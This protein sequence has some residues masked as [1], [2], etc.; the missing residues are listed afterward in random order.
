MSKRSGSEAVLRQ[1]IR[2]SKR[3]WIQQSFKRPGSICRCTFVSKLLSSFRSPCGCGRKS[4]HTSLG[5]F[6]TVLGINPPIRKKTSICSTR[7]RN[8]HR[9]LKAR[10]WF[11][12]TARENC[13]ERL[14]QWQA[15]RSIESDRV[16][17]TSLRIVDGGRSAVSRPDGES[18]TILFLTFDRQDFSTGS[19]R[20]FYK[21]SRLR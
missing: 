2:L 20:Q 10:L 13:D 4:R 5:F 16:S 8:A 18:R 14:K 6:P 12:S 17:G 21:S 11:F 19:V 1:Q 3:R 9:C 15:L 7:L